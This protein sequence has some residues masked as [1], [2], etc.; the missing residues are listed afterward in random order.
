V[1]SAPAAA[2]E[3]IQR[4]AG[5]AAREDG[6][7]GAFAQPYREAKFAVPRVSD[8]AE[9]DRH[10]LGEFILRI[11]REEGPVHEDEVL[12]RVR[13]LWNLGRAGSRLQ[14]AV[15]RA[16]ELLVSHQVC[17]RAEGFLQVRGAP[18]VVR[19]REEVA[20][21]GLRKPEMLPPMEIA[22]AILALVDAHHGATA[23]ELPSAVARVLGFKTT[24]PPLRAA[25][26]SVSGDLQRRGVL[27]D[28]GGMLRR[29]GASGSS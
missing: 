4:E 12:V 27:A 3:I 6:D 1:A 19:N 8:P 28:A 15:A 16:L 22:A 25:V 24:S 23:E 10:K 5:S 21:P 13:D 29:V 18:V 7:L 14:E 26:E 20:S 17:E 11:V 9:M 2:P